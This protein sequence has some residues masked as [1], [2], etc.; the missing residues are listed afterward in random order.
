MESFLISKVQQ[1]VYIKELEKEFTFKA[2][3][4]IH[5]EYS[6]K[7]LGEELKELITNQVFLLRKLI[8]TKKDGT[9]TYYSKSLNTKEIKLFNNLDLYLI[10]LPEIWDEIQISEAIDEYTVPKDRDYVF[11]Q[12]RINTFL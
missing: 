9:Q 12:Q 4:P 5:T 3:E 8:M 1:K 6:T 10:E 7:Y 11:Y 2:F